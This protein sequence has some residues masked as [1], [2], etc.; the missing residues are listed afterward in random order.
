[1]D[2]I[3]RLSVIFAGLS[4][5][6]AI[7]DLGFD[8]PVHV[9]R[10]LD[11]FY[12]TTLLTGL[13]S[14][15]VKYLLRSPLPS[16]K[17]WAFDLL[18]VVLIS[19]LLTALLLPGW[20]N[21]LRFP[22]KPDYW[23]TFF[24]LVLLIRELSEL[25]WQI[26]RTVI[27]PAQLFIGSFLLLILLGALLLMLPRAT[28]EGISFLDALFTSTSAVCVTGLIVV[29]TATYF[30]PLG[31]GIILMLIQIGGLG[32]LT[33]ASYFSFFFRGMSSFEN[34][35][36]IS[37]IVSAEK[38]GEVFSML[39]YI[40]V[41]TFSIEAISAGLIFFSVHPA[42]FTSW[43]DRLFFSL[44]HSVSA[45]CNAGFS[46]LSSGL[47]DEGLRFNYFLQFVI[48]L[49]FGLGGL[50]LRN[51]AFDLRS[52]LGGTDH[53][54]RT[55]IRQAA[56]SPAFL[57]NAVPSARMPPSVRADLTRLLLAARP[58]TLLF[59]LLLSRGTL[60]ATLRS[61]HA[62][63]QPA[64]TLLVMNAVAASSSDAG[65]FR[66]DQSWLPICLPQHDARGFVYAHIS[67]VTEELCL[68][69]LSPDRE[70]FPQLSEHRDAIVNKISASLSPSLTEALASPLPPL[71]PA[72]PEIFHFVYKLHA[73]GQ[74]TSPRIHC[75]SPYAQRGALKRLLRQ[76]QLAHAR[77]HV[78]YQPGKPPRI[79]RLCR[80]RRRRPALVPAHNHP[81][82]PLICR[83]CR[84]VSFRWQASARVHSGK[85]LGDDCGVVQPRV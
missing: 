49:T 36:T 22:G 20:L 32:I 39:R 64:D 29:D 67:F 28:Y 50:G 74:Y 7:L 56:S 75:S 11:G 83:P 68:V 2:Y 82:F 65:Q 62:S 72:N 78:S 35:L 47:Y 26:R 27:N 3:R 34:Q 31:Q 59:A 51:A 58:S 48:I 33:F 38:V 16:R 66:E 69:L 43:Y 37:D 52:L 42:S 73:T 45:F 71:P 77:V 63:L 1:L 85:R 8:H 55:L 19:W 81:P 79:G 80:C 41:I 40:L 60:V 10:L 6:F 23:I 4:I 53:L 70:A 17:V 30:T 9:D 15:G 14:L 84:T 46:T 25:Q 5:F 57:L 54:V 13:V 76:Y 12:I 21:H 18:L 61:K 44:F 24:I